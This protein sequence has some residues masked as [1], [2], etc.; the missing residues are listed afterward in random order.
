MAFEPLAT[1]ALAEGTGS[2]LAE[3]WENL[4]SRDLLA[5]ARTRSELWSLALDLLPRR[6]GPG[7]PPFPLLSVQDRTAALRFL[8]LLEEA[9]LFENF[10]QWDPGHLLQA[11]PGSFAPALSSR[12]AAEGCHWELGPGTEVPPRIERMPRS[13]TAGCQSRWPC[14]PLGHWCVCLSN[15]DPLTDLGPSGLVFRLPFWSKPRLLVYRCKATAF[16]PHRAGAV[17]ALCQGLGNDKGPERPA[18]FVNFLRDRSSCD[19]FA[20]RSSHKE[21]V[22]HWQQG[23]WISLRVAL[24][25]DSK[26]LRVDSKFPGRSEIEVPFADAACLGVNF[27]MLYNQTGDFEAS[28]TDI[29][30]LWRS[31]RPRCR[32]RQRNAPKQRGLG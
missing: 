17:L 32:L 25:W 13:A 5:L 21:P 18:V 22:G 8:P 3:V 6:L 29:L 15:E 19:I 10:A 14:M 4:I 16:R 28:W 26:M 1:L 9:P 7:V 24:D 20:A 30:L 11:A 12:A 27:L 23:E 31:G 2:T